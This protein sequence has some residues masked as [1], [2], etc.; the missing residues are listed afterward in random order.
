MRRHLMPTFWWRLDLGLRQLVPEHLLVNVPRLWN[1]LQEDIRAAESI[2]GLK[3]NIKTSWWH[4]HFFT[5]KS[6]FCQLN[7][8]LERCNVIVT[9]KIINHSKKHPQNQQNSSDDDLLLC[10]VLPFESRE[11]E[12]RWFPCDM[13]RFIPAW[14]C[15]DELCLGVYSR[16][17]FNPDY[18]PMQKSQGV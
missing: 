10:Y 2:S 11:E 9:G 18:M 5:Q 1:A 13:H 15:S 16:M 14:P 3:S 6:I 17:V 8:K 12:S 7:C 4:D